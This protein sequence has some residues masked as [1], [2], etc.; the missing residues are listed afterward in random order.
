ME[1]VFGFYKVKVGVCKTDKILHDPIIKKIP[2]WAKTINHYGT[3]RECIYP[4]GLKGGL[5]PG[6]WRG[7]WVIRPKDARI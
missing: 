6:C 7:L 3:M 2:V 1:Y 4:P 5:F